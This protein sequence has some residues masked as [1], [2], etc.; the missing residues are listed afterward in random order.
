MTGMRP[1]N[2]AWAGLAAMT[3]SFG[4]NFTMGVFFA[5]TAASYGVTATALTVAAA[6]GTS[7]T[8]LAQPSIGRLLDLLGAKIVLIGGLALISGSYLAL[9]TV[10]ET[11]QFVAAYMLLG[12]LGF[13]ASSTLTVTTLLGRAY[14]PQ[15]GPA[16]ARA[17][18]GINLGQLITPWAATALFGPVGVRGTFALLGAIGVAATAVLWQ[19]L[20]ADPRSKSNAGPGEP[21]A[22][23]W[24][25]LVSFGLHAAIL[26]VF[27]LMLPKH[28][29]EQGWSVAGAGRLVAL[30]ALA[31]GLSSAAMVR[32]LRRYPP[33]TLL[34]VLYSV[35]VAALLPA[36]FVPGPE[37]LVVV[38]VLFGIASFPAIPLTMAILS[39]GLDPA[40]MGRTLAP[41]W[42][43]HQLSAATGLGVATVVH[44]LTDSYRGYFALGLVFT[45]AATLLIT[46]VRRREPVT[47]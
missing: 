17:A 13:A 23:R 36:V 37:V 25:V 14:G 11:W 7:V 32:L 35:R 5:P 30:A 47:A 1:D 22:H 2:L 33:E 43:I 44:L 41:A 28:A 39:R 27:V 10:T 45:V 26:Y 8:G 3:V 46:P 4:L 31:A 12:G 40:R 19:L 34:R 20:P 21:L 6:L 38:A 18:I 9:A 29:V 16:M 42:V 24:K 15:A